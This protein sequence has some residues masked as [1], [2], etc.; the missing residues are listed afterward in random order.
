MSLPQIRG[1][2][3]GEGVPPTQWDT[4]T[5]GGLGHETLIA[6]EKESN[7]SEHSVQRKRP[8]RAKISVIFKSN[9]N[10]D[11]L[12]RFG[13]FLGTECSDQ[14]DS[15]SW[16]INLWQLFLYFAVRV[17]QQIFFYVVKI[18]VFE[19]MSEFQIKV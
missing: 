8:K 1:Q 3:E 6:C 13:R 17:T 14:V 11:I 4:A 10:A 19:N 12:A 18:E 2:P 7:W 9:K 5:R 15:F 16:A